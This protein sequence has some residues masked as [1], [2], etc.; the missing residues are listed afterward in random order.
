MSGKQV[1]L[2][3]NCPVCK[4]ETKELYLKSFERLSLKTVYLLNYDFLK[5]KNDNDPFV[6]LSQDNMVFIVCPK[7]GVVLSGDICEKEIDSNQF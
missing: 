6:R 1:I 3:H 7:C 2:K 5:E 4:Y